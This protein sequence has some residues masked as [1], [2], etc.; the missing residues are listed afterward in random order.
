LF[1]GQ[2]VAVVV[3]A[4][5]EERHIGGT[6]RSIPAWVD[7]VV[8][9][10]DRSVDG[11]Q[12]VVR[13]HA[14]GRIVCVRLTRN[15]GV[16]GAI[17]RGYREAHARGAHV[18]VV[19]AGD[20]QMDPADLPTV[21]AP[22]V[23]GSA[24]YVKGDR[25][26]HPDLLH[27]MPPVR[28]V[29]NFALSAL[30]RAVTGYHHLLDSQCGY[31]ALR[32]DFVP[33]LAGR[34]VYPRYGFPNDLLAHLAVLGARVA[35]VPVRPVYGSERS[36]IRWPLAMVTISALLARAWLRRLWESYVR[37]LVRGDLGLPALPAPSA[38]GPPA[39][40]PVPVAVADE[41]VSRQVG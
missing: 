10:D 9:V 6:L 15:L 16:G 26:T 41:P 8:V 12:D 36:G 13:R 37:P 18:I 21:V 1:R 7:L 40:A 27:V 35:D 24:D 31:T 39:P 3:P 5:N 14:S 4:H 2:R 38:V 22:V 29:G 25:L 30:T 20:G 34:A 19:M 17:L 11:T 28:I 23:D 33:R 32:A